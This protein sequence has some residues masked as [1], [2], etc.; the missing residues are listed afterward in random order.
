MAGVLVFKAIKPEKL[1]ED[2]MRLALLNPLHKVGRDIHADFKKTTATWQHKVEFEVAVSLALGGASVHVITTDRIYGYVND[3]TVPHPIFAGY[4]TGLSSK[5]ALSFQ[6]GGKGSY[7]AKTTPG[8]IGS[9]PGGPTG[10]RVAKPYV[11]H[12][13]SKARGFDV[14]IQKRWEP[15]FKT[16]M[17]QG[18]SDAATASGHSI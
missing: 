16:R 17:E 13:G 15:E 9:Q 4:Y 12:P 7:R 8:F 11:Q 18:M 3:G 5:R 14:A 10:P 6:W 1:K 2:A